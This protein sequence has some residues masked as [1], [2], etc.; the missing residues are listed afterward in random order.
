MWK[1][2]GLSPVSG[3]EVLLSSDAVV[4]WAAGDFTPEMLLNG[5]W[6]DYV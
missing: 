5:A 4:V 2:E 1:E 3:T 6:G